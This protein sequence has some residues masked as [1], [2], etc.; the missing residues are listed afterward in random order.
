MG[1]KQSHTVAI[2]IICKSLFSM[3]ATV[4]VRQELVLKCRSLFKEH[5]KL[6]VKKLAKFLYASLKSKKFQACLEGICS[7]V[8]ILQPKALG[9]IVGSDIMCLILE[10]SLDALPVGS[11]KLLRSFLRVVRIYP[12]RLRESLFWKLLEKGWRHREQFE[13]LKIIGVILAVLCK[14]KDSPAGF[15][16]SL[17][18]QGK[19][20]ISAGPHL[21]VADSTDP[22]LVSYYLALLRGLVSEAI[23]PSNLSEIF[24]KFVNLKVDPTVNIIC[25]ECLSMLCRS[26]DKRHFE[27]F[28]RKCTCVIFDNWEHPV[29]ALVEKCRLLLA[30]LLRS[31]KEFPEVDLLPQF[32]RDVRSLP[33]EK[34]TRF[35]LIE[36]MLKT[37]SIPGHVMQAE[38][39]STLAFISD[40]NLTH[41]A[42]TLCI[43]MIRLDSEC[44]VSSLANFIAATECERGR[45]FREHF[46]IPLTRVLFDFVWRVFVEIGCRSSQFLVSMLRTE[47]LRVVFDG[48]SFIYNSTAVCSVSMLRDFVTLQSLE[49][50][51]NAM[52]VILFL[53]DSECLIELFLTGLN[54]SFQTVE[55]E[56]RHRL[57]G[58]IERFCKLFGALDR[59]AEYVV[60]NCRV[61]LLCE[62]C[63]QRLETLLCLVKSWL[64]SIKDES[65]IGRFFERFTN[66]FVSLLG[67][68]YQDVRSEC[69]GILY[70]HKK[71]LPLDSSLKALSY[72]WMRSTHMHE[73]EGGA[74]LFLILQG[75][76]DM[77]LDLFLDAL[78]RSAASA[79]LQPENYF[80]DNF[81]LVG[82]IT[83]FKLWF[84]QSKDFY[85]APKVLKAR[86]RIFQIVLPVLAHQSPEGA[87]PDEYQDDLQDVVV[88]GRGTKSQLLACLS[89]R[90]IK[91]YSEC[92]QSFFS[93]KEFS[94]EDEDFFA[95][96]QLFRQMLREI[97]HR[98]AF[99]AVYECF[100]VM[101]KRLSQSS[102]WKAPFSGWLPQE[103]KTLTAPDQ[104]SDVTRRS[105]GIPYLFLA[106]TKASFNRNRSILHST[107]ERLVH[108]FTDLKTS[109]ESKVH[110]LNISRV[111]FSDSCVGSDASC[112]AGNLFKVL[113]EGFTSGDWRVRN[114]C[115]LTFSALLVR[116]FGGSKRAARSKESG[117]S[118]SDFFRRFSTPQVSLLELIEAQLVEGTKF[119][120]RDT[121][122]HPALFPILSLLSRLS[123]GA[124]RTEETAPVRHL[125]L[126]CLSSPV[127]RLREIAGEALVACCDSVGQAISLVK[128]FQH[129]KGNNFYHGACC[130]ASSFLRFYAN[131]ADSFLLFYKNEVQPLPD[132]HPLVRYCWGVLFPQLE[133]PVGVDWGG[134][135]FLALQ[136]PYTGHSNCFVFS[137]HPSVAESQSRLLEIL[138][139]GCSVECQCKCLELLQGSDAVLLFLC[140]E[141]FF[142]CKSESLLIASISYVLKFFPSHTLT[143]ALEYANAKHSIGVRQA[144]AGNLK[145]DQPIEQPEQIALFV[146]L[147]QDEEVEIRNAASVYV[148]KHILKFADTQCTYECL[149]LLLQLARE[150]GL[151]SA[152]EHMFAEEDEPTTD[153]EHVLFATE[154]FNI[155]REYHLER[156]L[157]WLLKA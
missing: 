60:E 123:P 95:T 109:S 32:L 81:L 93:A 75:S 156:Y 105:A 59:T 79:Q 48:G 66:S 130:A 94:V 80:Y 36:A 20:P 15:V 86:D 70:S 55:S 118:F 153:T 22:A 114:A 120:F 7:A 113:I 129:Q 133:Q 83:L 31:T 121:N 78:E 96:A 4:Q 34:S 151:L 139:S 10:G 26:I 1:S 19:I 27:V 46:L 155:F 101:C 116:L 17:V 103:L 84:Q 13:Q 61:F 51:L 97:R 50:R 62:S 150:K 65:V 64:A 146:T 115:L 72:K 63:S 145:M 29:N 91:E 42:S 149:R 58:L 157:L 102:T 30:E 41:R 69:F 24:F 6:I 152:L 99:L 68:T 28:W 25:L 2:T 18:D 117:I 57:F 56:A 35:S 136:L 142:R 131:S 49:E 148:S 82:R 110:I 141:I 8:E 143:I 112:F 104:P 54:C 106:L 47:K 76:V 67:H 127:F 107:L 137:R 154:R 44:F 33:M 43:L 39:T 45:F 138:L 135:D 119:I 89:W 23:L 21:L 126:R 100:S 37:G 3:E 132:L 128:T 77:E 108:I 134:C 38:F 12:L 124:G 16:P 122:L 125:V 85:L 88:S 71:F 73:S 5:Q 14:R 53:P 74:M 92:L 147:L 40:P 144:V 90:L 9:H 87:I 111:L 11:N 140:N 98:G 52:E